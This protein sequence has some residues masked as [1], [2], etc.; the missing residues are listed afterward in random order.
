MVHSRSYDC[1]VSSS[2]PSG[3]TRAARRSWDARR[4]AIQCRGSGSMVLLWS[5]VAQVL[6]P[7]PEAAHAPDPPFGVLR[8]A[9]DELVHSRVGEDEEAVLDDAGQD[10][11]GDGVGAL[12]VAATDG[13]GRLLGVAAASG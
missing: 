3:S 6:G 2:M 11:G 5:T 10:R 1:P 8:L 13:G 9:H 7:I 4:A 12:H